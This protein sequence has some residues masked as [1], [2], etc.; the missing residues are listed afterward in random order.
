MQGVGWVN[1]DRNRSGTGNGLCDLLG[2]HTRLANT[3]DDDLAAAIRYKVDRLFNTSFI[4]ISRGV[5]DSRG[6]KSEQF[7]NFTKMV[8]HDFEFC[9]LRH[10]L[11]S[12]DQDLKFATHVGGDCAIEFDYIRFHSGGMTPTRYLF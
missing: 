1:K 2:Y 10:N 8:C 11:S 9:G 7:H 4:E 6:F 5:F 3:D 12:E